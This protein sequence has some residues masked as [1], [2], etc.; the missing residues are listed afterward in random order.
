M[1][2]NKVIE[3]ITLVSSLI[4]IVLGNANDISFG[5]RTANPSYL[6]MPRMYK[7]RYPVPTQQRHTMSAVPT[8]G[9]KLLEPQIV[10]ELHQ[11]YTVHAEQELASKRNYVIPDNEL[12]VRDFTHM[13]GTSD[14]YSG[15][16]I[17]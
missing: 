10:D 14:N 6:R 2:S 3:Y 17:R 7:S 16:E 4:V 12:R 9:P 5:N 15:F 13:H 8:Q 11:N 1:K